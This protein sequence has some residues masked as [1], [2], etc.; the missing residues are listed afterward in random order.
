MMN[1][2]QAA[3]KRYANLKFLWQKEKEKNASL[4]EALEAT[5]KFF[6]YSPEMPFELL[7]EAEELQVIVKQA[8]AKVGEA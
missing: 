3:E 4:V 1:R 7:A 8:L 6:D 5:K 2:L